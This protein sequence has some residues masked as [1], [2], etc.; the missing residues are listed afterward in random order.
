MDHNVII[1]ADVGADEGLSPRLFGVKA[2]AAATHTKRQAVREIRQRRPST[3][4]RNVDA[5]VGSGGIVN[6]WQPEHVTRNTWTTL[7]FPLVHSICFSV[8]KTLWIHSKCGTMS[9]NLEGNLAQSVFW[10]L[11]PA[12][13]MSVS[14]LQ[15]VSLS[16][17]STIPV[18]SSRL[19]MDAPAF[20]L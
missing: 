1:L 10:V 12:I 3:K 20:G 18:P 9:M 16:P 2:A 8:A 6:A 15:S 7:S 11:L 14:S 5:N 4:A 17:R 19:Q 13:P